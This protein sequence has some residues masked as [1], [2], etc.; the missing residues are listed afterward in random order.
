MRT[1]LFVAT[2]SLVACSTTGVASKDNDTE[3]SERTSNKSGGTSAAAGGED[4]GPAI[5]PKAKLMFEDTVK[6]Y[7]GQVKAGKVD[8]AQMDE[9][10]KHVAEADDNLAEAVYNRGVIAEK[11]G[12]TMDAIAFYKEALQ[13]K[14]S[15]KQAR[16]NL[17]VIAQNQGNEDEAAKIYESILQA[18]PDDASSRA[19]LA[20]I[21]RR[22]GDGE[23]ALQLA[24][25][26]LFRDPKTLQAYKTMMLV[27][28]EQK[29]FSMARLCALRATK[30]QENDPEIFFTLGLINLAEKEP[31]K[32]RVQF[33]NA[34][35]A[36]PD[37]LPAH[38]ELEKMAMSQEDYAGAEE[39]IRQILRANGKN[40]EAL[41]DLGV[42][43]KGM[44]QFDKAL[45]AYDAAQKINANI[46][47][48]YFNRGL[49]RCHLR[50]R[51]GPNGRPE[52]AIELFK[53]Y[54]SMAGGGT[55][56]PADHGV[57]KAMKAEEAVIQRREEDKKAAE[58]AAKMEAEMKKQEDAAKAA[59]TQQKDA[60]LKKTQ[61]DAKGQPA[62]DPGKGGAAPA[63]GAATPATGG[64]TKGGDKKAPD[65]KKGG[66]APAAAGTPAKKGD[67][68]SET[69]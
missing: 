1:L 53:A 18:Y 45:E 21:A 38:L 69:P 34:I 46:P 12:K 8:L 52:K 26:A 59:E 54:I 56:L 35:N 41:V 19:R 37:F 2:F 30:I 4:Q 15:L 68:P 20:E 42:A 16:E 9:R 13:R 51:G 31:A 64:D 29:Q 14:P 55:S 67:E 39:S 58:E 27:N 40:A 62:A 11:Q 44:G 50:R 32:A 65:A 49:H 66:A 7:E 10:W 63:G 3:R 5:N 6:T 47:A 61:G 60:D 28:F 24:K 36:R 23:K 57:F 17:G 43:L 22:K 25:E 33:K 48:I